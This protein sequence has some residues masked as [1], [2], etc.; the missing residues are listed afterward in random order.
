MSNCMT[1]TTQDKQ[2]PIDV[3]AEDFQCIEYNNDD[4]DTDRG[5]MRN[6][7]FEITFK[8]HQISLSEEDFENMIEAFKP[9]VD[10]ARALQKFEH[11]MAEEFAK[12]HSP[13]ALQ[14]YTAVPSAQDLID[15][16]KYDDGEQ[17]DLDISRICKEKK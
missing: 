3:D 9:Y 11:E 17:A 16:V 5:T 4:C 8:S 1:N 14:D 7:W 2:D 13:I 10:N 12:E 6:R 15:Q